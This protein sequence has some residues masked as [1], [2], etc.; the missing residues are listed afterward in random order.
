[1]L[2]TDSRKETMTQAPLNEYPLCT[3]IL[4]QFFLSI[5]FLSFSSCIKDSAGIEKIQIAPEFETYWNNFLIEAE[6]RDI[7]LMV[8]TLAFKME[9]AQLDTIFGP[10]T[11]GLCQSESGGDILID[12]DVWETLHDNGKWGLIYH[13]LGHCVLG[14]HHTNPFGNIDQNLRTFEC[15]SLMTGCLCGFGCG[16]DFDSEMWRNFY[17]DE[18]FGLAAEPAWINIGTN[19]FEN[20][21][22]EIAFELFESTDNEV[23]IPNPFNQTPNFQ[24]EVFITG[25]KDF[26]FSKDQISFDF[27]AE[28][29][30]TSII[31]NDILVFHL[32]FI[33]AWKFLN[34]DLENTSFTWR[35]QF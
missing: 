28:I 34:S 20:D 13:E 23:L 8:D 3:K 11:A 31:V 19:Y 6:A 2:N 33:N 18:F 27:K 1:M 9:F 7:D 16:I 4:L 21:F 14:R 30:E 22:E 26:Q 12:T 17:L 15:S 24:L 25:H 29:G 32:N 10:S 35:S 5:L